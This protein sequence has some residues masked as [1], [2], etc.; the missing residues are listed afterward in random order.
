M[1]A[2]STLRRVIC[3]AATALALTAGAGC[4]SV[5]YAEDAGRVGRKV[6]DAVRGGT[7]SGDDAARGGTKAERNGPTPGEIKDGAGKTCKGGDAV[8]ESEDS[9]C[10]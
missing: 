8:G 1:K 6:D 3:I 10:W 2:G 4:R 9:P 7:R 5:Q